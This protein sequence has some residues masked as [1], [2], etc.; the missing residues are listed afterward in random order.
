MVYLGGGLFCYELKAQQSCVRQP[1][2]C[3]LLKTTDL[4]KPYLSL[5]FSR[6]CR[7]STLLMA[8]LGLSTISTWSGLGKDPVL[9]QNTFSWSPQTWL[10]LSQ[11][12]LGNIQHL[13]EVCSPAPPPSPLPL[14]TKSWVINQQCEC[15]F[16]RF[17]ERSR[18]VN[19][20]V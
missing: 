10:E 4:L 6:L 12:L 3:V 1:N 8:Q 9:A 19:C 16:T 17:A 11:G 20:Q 7:D 18:N 5:C 2:H 13:L 14:D 15:D